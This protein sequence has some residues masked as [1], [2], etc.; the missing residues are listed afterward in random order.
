VT[1]SEFLHF[2]VDVDRNTA[3]ISGSVQLDGAP[4]Q[5]F[6]GWTELF[7]ALEV[8]IAQPQKSREAG[9]KGSGLR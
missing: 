3:P 2:Q 1:A 8:A 7:A 4:A 9:P 6:A 5:P